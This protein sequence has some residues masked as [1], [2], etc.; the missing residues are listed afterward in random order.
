MVKKNGGSAFPDQYEE[1]M[2]L[3]DY[4]AGQALTGICAMGR[5]TKYTPETQGSITAKEA[6]N[7]AEAML[8]EGNYDRK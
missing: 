1:G 7:L 3:K 6:Y 4:F 5:H 8:E 2:T